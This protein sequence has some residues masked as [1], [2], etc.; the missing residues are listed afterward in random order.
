MFLEKDKINNKIV[1]TKGRKI[2]LQSGSNDSNNI[3]GV[4]DS[5]VGSTI[6]VINS[7]NYNFNDPVYIVIKLKTKDA[8]VTDKITMKEINQ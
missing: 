6:K 2:N 1:S 5:I 4:G 8:I 3:P 7:L